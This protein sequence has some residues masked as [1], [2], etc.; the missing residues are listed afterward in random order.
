M[1]LEADGKTEG[2]LEIVNALLR[3]PLR[4]ESFQRDVETRERVHW[5]APLA[6]ERVAINTLIALAQAKEQQQQDPEFVG[7]KA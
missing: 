4:I 6:T 5:T 2:N 1:G 7:A 3:K